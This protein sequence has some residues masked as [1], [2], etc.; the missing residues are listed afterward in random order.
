M[1]KNKPIIMCVDDDPEVLASIARDLRCKYRKDYRIVQANCV[2]EGMKTAE[3][4]KKRGIPIAL[5]LV[6]QKMPEMSGTEFLSKMIHLH[7]ESAKVLLTAY[8][9]TEAAIVSINKIGLDHYLLKPWDPPEQK[10]Y[11]HDIFICCV[12]GRVFWL[13]GFSS[14][15][16]RLQL[17]KCL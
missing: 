10:L 15:Y 11:P 5:F 17:Y 16:I 14:S 9:D 12:L 13:C 7:P 4:I 1:Q 3:L 8:S 2:L 6:D